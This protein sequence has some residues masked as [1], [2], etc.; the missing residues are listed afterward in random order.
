MAVTELIRDNFSRSAE[1][2]EQAAQCQAHAA[3]VLAGM[4]AAQC[5]L[6]LPSIVDWGVGTGFLSR[7]LFA[8]YPQA[9]LTAVDLSPQMIEQCKVH[10]DFQTAL[11]E[12][13]LRFI[14]ADLREFRLPRMT[15]IVASGLTLQWVD[16]IG[17]TLQTLS[18]QLS[19][20][21]IFA[22]S[23]LTAGTFRDLHRA[24]E[25]LKIPYPGPVLL[26][27]ETLTEQVSS[28]LTLLDHRSETW[29][30]SHPSPADFLRQV[31]RTGAVNASGHPL[32]PG[33]LRQILR[34][35]T[36]HFS[37]TDGSVEIEYELDYWIGRI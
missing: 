8:Y 23:T 12:R 1:S 4:I 6:T 10:P 34:Y 15:D 7:E 19:P 2:Y 25:A 27:R 36:E 11:S 16:P 26:S 28:T 24:F 22:F 33:I 18:E 5:K 3:K 20:G 14:T 35:Y 32:S 17:P 30:E 13:R 29:R 9:V 37:R 21:A 31:R